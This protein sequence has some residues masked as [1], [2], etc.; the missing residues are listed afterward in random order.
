MLIIIISLYLLI[1]G[2]SYDTGIRPS[3]AQ[4]IICVLLI[5]TTLCSLFTVTSDL[6]LGEKVV[7]DKDRGATGYGESLIGSRFAVG[8][9]HAPMHVGGGAPKG[10]Y[11]T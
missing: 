5:Q 11:N 6:L 1:L 4:V 8:D 7:A 2:S 9:G 10:M 3:I